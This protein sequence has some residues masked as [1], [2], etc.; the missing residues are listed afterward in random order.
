MPLLMPISKRKLIGISGIAG[1]VG[2][3]RAEA[4]ALPSVLIARTK[5]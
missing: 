5:G 3:R 4:A 2:H 1:E